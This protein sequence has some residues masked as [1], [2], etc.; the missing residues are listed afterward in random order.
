MSNPAPS[1]ARV[2]SLVADNDRAIG[3]R[4]RLF[5][6]LR[7]MSLEELALQSKVSEEDLLK[8]ESGGLR[9]STAQVA[10]IAAVLGIPSY[11]LIVGGSL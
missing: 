2:F 8:C 4:I 9:P 7:L 5:R 10:A 1:R 11:V 6:I 3:R